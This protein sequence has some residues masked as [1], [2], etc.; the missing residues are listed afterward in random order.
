MEELIEEPQDLIT[1]NLPA[2]LIIEIPEI[3]IY[4]ISKLIGKKLNVRFSL[5]TVDGIKEFSTQNYIINDN[6]LLLGYQQFIN[7]EKVNLD[8]VDFYL[9]NNMQ[10]QIFIENIDPVEK[11]G[12]M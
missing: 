12:R 9:N 8:I 3:I 11:L 1:L 4:D 2:H 10:I 5:M 7:L 6:K